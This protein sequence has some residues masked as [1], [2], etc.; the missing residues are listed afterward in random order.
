MLFLRWTCFFFLWLHSFSANS[1]TFTCIPAAPLH[2]D[3]VG[4]TSVPDPLPEPDDCSGCL[5]NT[6]YLQNNRISH[7]RKSDFTNSNV[8]CLQKL[9]LHNNVISSIEDGCFAGTRLNS[10]I[11]AG[12]LLTSFPDFTEVKHTL[13]YIDLTNN[14][15][16][17]IRTA[18]LPA[19]NHLYMN[20]NPLVSFPDYSDPFP[21]LEALMIGPAAGVRCC[22]WMKENQLFIDEPFNCSWPPQVVGKQWDDISS[23]DLSGTFCQGN[24]V[25]FAYLYTFYTCIVKKKLVVTGKIC[26]FKYKFEII[27][28]LLLN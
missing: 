10:I 13:T 24:K 18:E 4:C 7:I 2:M 12:N 14:S 11:L 1:A 22:I 27:L 9:H 6:I 20:G 15:I 17:M 8:P 26:G 19:L 23:D 3:G 28:L 25:P 5:Y 21:A 16:T